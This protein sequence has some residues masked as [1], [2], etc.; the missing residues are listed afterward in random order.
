MGFKCIVFRI[1]KNILYKT[2]SP[3]AYNLSLVF[4][5]TS[6]AMFLREQDHCSIGNLPT[7]LLWWWWLWYGDD[8]DICKIQR[9]HV[10][11]SPPEI[12]YFISCNLFLKISVPIVLFITI[13]C[14]VASLFQCWCM[15]SDLSSGTW[16]FKVF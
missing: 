11:F 15:T 5:T 12:F 16:G 7:K 14:P 6:K 10:G 8:Y 4:L 9:F 2:K 13:F 1:L 3:E